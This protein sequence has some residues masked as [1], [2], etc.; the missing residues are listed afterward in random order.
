MAAK[1]TMNAAMKT[2]KFLRRI[3]GDVRNDV[4][5]KNTWP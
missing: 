5:G 1:N 3:F 4:G 2:T